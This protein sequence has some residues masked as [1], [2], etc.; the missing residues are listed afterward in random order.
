MK[1]ALATPWRPSAA[2]FAL[3]AVLSS[4]SSSTADRTAGGEDFPNTLE[5]LGRALAEGVDSSASW[6]SL[7]E[8]STSPVAGLPDSLEFLAG[9]ARSLLCTPDSSYGPLPDGFTYLRKTTCPAGGRVEDSLV[10]RLSD[11]VVRVLVRDSSGLLGLVRK[12]QTFVADSGD[13]FRLKGYAG[14]VRIATVAT[15]GKW[16]A[17]SELVLDAGADLDWDTEADNALWRGGQATIRDE[18]DT[19]DRWSVLP[20]ARRAGPVYDARTGDSGRASVERRQILSDGAVRTESSVV[21]AFRRDSLNYPLRFRSRLRWSEALW[22]ESSVF[23]PR[24]DS[25]FLP[26]D[27]AVFLNRRHAGSDSV[28]EEIR[29]LA[30]PDPRD[31]SGDRL[32]FLSSTRRHAGRSE[33]EVRMEA[34]PSTPLVSDA[35]F[36]DGRIVLRV[37][38]ADGDT[39]RF[40]GTMNAGVSEGR[41]KTRSDSGFVRL[42]SRGRVLGTAP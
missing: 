3:A 31:R 21:M 32:V 8:A 34:A 27:T 5:A 9:R 7:D 16:R 2:A 36:T 15:K 40:E 33:V 6:N 19:V 23:G 39:I 35:V 30:G 17:E 28:R 37:L 12:V 20:W 38:R 22:K 24:E 11:S 10:I 29:F 14:R 4:C 41:W 42:D 26:G 18:L 13:G 1:S 25:V